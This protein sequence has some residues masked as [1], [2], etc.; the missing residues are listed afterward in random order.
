MKKILDVPT[1]RSVLIAGAFRSFGNM[2]VSCY[3]PVFFQKIY[4]NYTSE[5]AI[6]SALSLLVF[7]FSSVLLGGIIGDKYS[8]KYHMTNALIC[9]VGA[10]IAIPL[11]AI[12]TIFH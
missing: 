3:L 12:G 11:I 4:P 10:L 2:A 7:G 9:M 1:C 6:I 8:Q 5:Y